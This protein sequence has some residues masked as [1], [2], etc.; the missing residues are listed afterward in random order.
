MAEGAE[1]VTALF[2]AIGRDDASAIDALLAKSPALLGAT[3]PGQESPLLAAIYRRA[4][5]AAE[6]LIAAGARHDAFTAAATGDVAILPAVLDAD[7]DAVRRRSADG[8]TPLHL[9]AFFGHPDAARWLLDRGADPR[10]RSTNANANEPLHAAAVQGHADVADLLLSRGADVDAVAGG[11]HT[12]LTLAAASGH[13][14][15]VDALLARGARTDLREAGGQDA[16]A[17]AEARGHAAIA[18]RLAGRP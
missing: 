3:S 13:A 17:L 14:A 16:R 7:P 6:R 4:W 1:D 18:A 8:W 12:A 15:V 2:D 11:G 10:A 9:E 5:H